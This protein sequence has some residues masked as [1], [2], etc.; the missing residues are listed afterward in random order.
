MRNNYKLLLFTLIFVF[1]GHGYLIA[2][3]GIIRGFIYEEETGEPAIFCNI[4]LVGTLY[5]AST[6]VNGF[7]VI[8]KINPGNYT[9]SITYLGYDTINKKVKVMPDDI[10]SQNF[11]L[12]K[13][14]FRLETI[15]I[16]AKRAAAR[17]ETNTSVVKITPKDIK[18]H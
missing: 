5:G 10:I 17:T 2:Q 16:S 7:F 4:V 11:F 1:F 3:Q 18:H 13:S 12:K 6:D 14:A 8:S 15:T 9:L